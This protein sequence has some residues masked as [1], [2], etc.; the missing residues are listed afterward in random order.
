MS[1]TNLHPAEQLALFMTRIYEKRLT[2]TSGGNLSIRDEA[3]NIWIT[4]AAVDKGT[5]TAADMVC[6]HPDGTVEGTHRPSSELPFHSNIYRLRPDLTAVIHAH[7]PGLLAAS[8]V[9]RCPDLGLLPMLRQVCGQVGLAAYAAPGS[10][11][12]GEYIGGCFADGCDLV[13]LENHGVCV[14]GKDLTDAFRKFET[15]EYAA[16]LEIC[17]RRLGTPKT[18][19]TAKEPEI[20]TPVQETSEALVA[21][22]RRAEQQGLFT[23]AMGRCAIR[24]QDGCLSMGVD[25]VPRF[26]DSGRLAAIFAAHPQVHAVIEAQPL[27]AMAFAVSGTF[28]DT[29]AIPESY[30]MLR[31]LIRLPADASAEVVAQSLCETA[32]AALLENNCALVIG[33]DLLQAFDRL[34]VLETTAQS[35]LDAAALGEIARMG[36]DRIDE[37]K[38]V[39]KLKD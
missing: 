28:Y 23:S 18:V 22:V 25:E 17:A 4:P 39:F 31:D 12:L 6:V 10:Q 24:W 29:R 9:R 8:M 5:L 35:L 16:N 11:L 7:P 33:K 38:V 37:I 32:P 15:L 1:G 13:L 36:Q 19:R 30:V 27:H 2:T 21:M 14:G 34:E 3:G 26:S 20:G